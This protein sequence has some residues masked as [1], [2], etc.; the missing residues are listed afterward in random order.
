MNMVFCSTHTQ[1]LTPRG[2]YKP[3]NVL[4]YPAYV[5]CQYRA[6]GGFDVE[7]DMQI[8][9]TEGLCHNSCGCYDAVAPSGRMVIEC[10]SLPIGRCPMLVAV[11]PL[12]AILMIILLLIGFYYSFP[13]L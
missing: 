7:N 4:V 9:F 10:V 13:I 12:G 2:I 6:T 3:T 1:H 5:L 11:C 8:Y